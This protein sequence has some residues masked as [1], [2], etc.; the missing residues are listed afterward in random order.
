MKMVLIN[1]E[2]HRS[3]NLCVG[4]E[5]Q[6]SARQLVDRSVVLSIVHCVY[7]IAVIKPLLTDVIS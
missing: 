7:N 6:G 2:M 1:T 4:E 5:T 3:K